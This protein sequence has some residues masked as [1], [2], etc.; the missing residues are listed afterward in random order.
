MPPARTKRK[1]RV[2]RP[3]TGRGTRILV[4]LAAGTALELEG[5]RHR[6]GPLYGLSRSAAAARAI[7]AYLAGEG[8]RR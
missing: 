7:E 2:G 5:R 3:R 1:L 8:G 4:V 6:E